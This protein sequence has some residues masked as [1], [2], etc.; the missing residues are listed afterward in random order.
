MLGVERYGKRKL[1]HEP[2]LLGETRNLFG[3]L[4]ILSQ[5]SNFYAVFNFRNGSDDVA[6]VT[7]DAYNSC[8]TST[9]I[10]YYNNSP[11]II[12]LKSAGEHY[13]TSTYDYHCDLGQKL[14]INVTGSSTASPPSSSGSPTPGSAT[15]PSSSTG[16][17]PTAGGPTPPPP[18]SAAP[19]RISNGFLFTLLPIVMAFIY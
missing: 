11:A 6:V 9:S 1:L 15:S 4:R 3:L 13:F 17:G 10:A 16:E 18:A 12:T 14:A 5:C 19:Y 2:N 7:K 8:N